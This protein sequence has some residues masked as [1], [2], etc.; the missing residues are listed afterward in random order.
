M[1]HHPFSFSWTTSRSAPDNVAGLKLNW[2]PD[3]NH[4]HALL[5]RK[6]EL[7]LGQQLHLHVNRDTEGVCGSETLQGLPR[8]HN[9]AMSHLPIP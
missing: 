3:I 1:P 5:L 9:I 4:R 6:Q 8:S 2:R 7:L